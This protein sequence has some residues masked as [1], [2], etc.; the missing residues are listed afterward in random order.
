MG[1]KTEKIIILYKIFILTQC[2]LGIIMGKVV[3]ITNFT[4]H[5][6]KI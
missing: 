3:K 2:Y 6:T 5:C 1:A 4:H